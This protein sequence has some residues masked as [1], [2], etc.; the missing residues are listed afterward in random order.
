MSASC[1]GLWD[2][3]ERRPRSGTKLPPRDASMAEMFF[4]PPAAI[5]PKERSNRSYEGLGTPSAALACGFAAERG[6]L[7]WLR[8][9]ERDGGGADVVVGLALFAGGLG[10]HGQR[11][12]RLAQ[13]PG[14]V[15][16]HPDTEAVRN[17]FRSARIVMAGD[18]GMI[19]SARL[20]GPGAGA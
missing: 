1:K 6:W 13:L 9:R 8:Q 17:K 20:P 19:T 7:S 10:E 3:A 18:R 14:Q 2:G 16:G 11:R 15:G 4:G 12:P 5:S